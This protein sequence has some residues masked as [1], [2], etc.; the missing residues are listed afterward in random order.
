MKTEAREFFAAA[1]TEQGFYS[2]FESVF[3]PNAFD[4]IFIIKGG[5]GSGKSTLMRQIAQY[6]RE[7]GCRPELYYCSSDTSSLDGIVIPERSCAV[8]DGTSPHM[9]DPK[10]PG[11]CEVIVSLYD[12]FDVSALRSRRDEVIELAA[13][14]ARLYHAAYRFLSAAGRVHREIEESALSSYDNEKAE[15][16]QR[17]LLRA[18]KLPTAKGGKSKL[19]YVDAI[20]TSGIV[21]L[22]TLERAAGTIYTVSDKYGL[23]GYFLTC[24]C[25]MCESMG[26][27][28]VKCPSPLR[29]DR[30]EA[31]YA[32]EAD[33]LL[34]VCR[35]EEKLRTSDKNINILR[36]ADKG[37]LSAMRRKLKFSGRCYDCLMHAA[38]E[39]LNGVKHAHAALEA[40]YGE[41]I[42]FSVVESHRDAILRDIFADNI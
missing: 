4:K 26:V 1:N 40:I 30:I 31:L 20:G 7:Q 39:N 27:S 10:Y 8:I 28:L 41:N 12:A 37:K 35:D 15:N 38:Q 24:F 36:F 22:H 18:M 42:D 9:T 6:A 29:T 33:T 21:H 23:G 5:P 16:A 32:E 25:R 34:Y 14:T 11:A 3:S 13:E 17:R 2:I 19:R